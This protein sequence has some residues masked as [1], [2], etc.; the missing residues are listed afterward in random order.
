MTTVNR[1][2]S[3]PYEMKDIFSKYRYAFRIANGSIQFIPFGDNRGKESLKKQMLCTF[4]EVWDDSLTG[5]KWKRYW[6]CSFL[7]IL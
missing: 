1:I 5:I 7:K 4:L 3:W 6:G 2:G